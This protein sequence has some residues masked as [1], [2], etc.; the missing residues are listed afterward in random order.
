M[1]EKLTSNLNYPILIGESLSFGDLIKDIG[2]GQKL[3][4]VVDETTNKL[5][6]DQFLA[7]I[8]NS[9]STLQINKVVIKEGETNKNWQ[10]LQLI[11]DSLIANNH[12][13]NTTI[14]ALG[15]GIVGDI[16]GFAAACFLRG[17]R[18]IQIPT[19]L[20]S[21]VDS[22]VGGKTGINHTMG[23]NL[24]GS[25]YQPQAVFIDI[26]FLKHLPKRQLSAGLAEVLKYGLIADKPFY[27]WLVVNSEK[28]INCDTDAI[29]YAIKKSC[30]TKADIVAADTYEQS[31]RALLNFGHT[32]GHAIETATGY[33]QY[34]H[35]EAVA[36]GMLMAIATSKILY[37]A[38]IKPQVEEQLQKLYKEWGLPTKCSAGL[39]VDDYLKYFKNDK[40]VIDNSSRFILLK[41]IGQAYIETIDIQEDSFKNLIEQWI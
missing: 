19:T 41:I 36:I 38:D 29:I 4:L 9:F 32:F 5:F 28:L 34:L 20:L 16:A 31:S 10:N 15:G 30:Q 13:R 14:V 3:M 18:L 22:S 24:I 12:D 27:D 11:I 1:I 25:F 8:N 17:V 2:I 21:Q 33:N 40:K 6:A 39:T 26:N 23:K 35:G 7:A 37:S